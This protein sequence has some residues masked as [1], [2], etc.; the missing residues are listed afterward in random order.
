MADATSVNRKT[1]KPRPPQRGELVG[2]RFQPDLLKLI[3]DWRREQADPPT[4]PEAIR[5]LV[6]KALKKD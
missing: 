2:T 5:R 4:R 1:R 3:D 6:V